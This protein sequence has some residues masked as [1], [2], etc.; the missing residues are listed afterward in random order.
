MRNK[1]KKPRITPA[2]KRLAAERKKLA[3]D[4]EKLT[5]AR[6]LRKLKSLGRQLDELR[7]VYHAL[8][9][10]PRDAE[11]TRIVRRWLRSWRR[12]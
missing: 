11:A 12:L 3:A 10:D 6:D 8:R 5:T 4:R 9:R 7:T 2:Q 1:D